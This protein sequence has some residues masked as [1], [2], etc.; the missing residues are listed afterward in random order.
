MN[1][2][3]LIQNHWY[4]IGTRLKLS[5]GILKEIWKDATR[6]D[7]CPKE[8]FCCC[9]M[10]LHWFKTGKNLTVKNFLEAVQ[11]APLGLDKKIPLIKSLLVDETTDKSVYSSSLSGLDETEK[12]YAVMIAEVT[13]IISKSDTPLDKFKLVLH[14]SKNVHTNRRKID[15]EVYENASSFS[16]LIDSLQNYGHIT[17]TE[18]SWLKYLVHDVA[19]SSEAL[20][21]I[22]RYEEINIAHK[23]HWQSMSKTE[24]IQGTFLIAKTSKDPSMLKGNDL[25]QAKSAA[26]KLVGL[27]ETDTVLDSAGVGSVIIYWKVYNGFTVALPGSI[28]PSLKQMCDKADITHIGMMVN[29]TITLMDIRQIKI[30]IG[31]HLSVFCKLSTFNIVM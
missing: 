27:D 13:G 28:T 15:K 19:K 24:G 29:H 22:K 21:V 5:E 9:K 17:H 20:N 18:L 1:T 10:L 7:V 30:E 12:I 14:H 23:I 11:L 6:A 16:T 8:T 31:K 26:V 2:V 3:S 25:S 4:V